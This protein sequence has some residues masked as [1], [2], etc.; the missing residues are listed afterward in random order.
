M[1]NAGYITAA[2]V[3][4]WVLLLGYLIHL[5]RVARRAAEQYAE[6]SAEERVSR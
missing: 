4:T 2:Y 3:V 6:A 1:P 5:M